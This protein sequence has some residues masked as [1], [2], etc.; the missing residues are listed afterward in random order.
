MTDIIIKIMAELLSVLALATKQIKQGRFSKYDTPYTFLR[1]QCV[2]EKFARKLLGE[3]EVEA[4]LQRLDRL[5][6]D[7]ARMTVAQTLGVVHGLMNNMK[8]VMDGRQFFLD[9]S[10]KPLLSAHYIRWGGIYERHS[11]SLGYVPHSVE[12]FPCSLAV[13]VTL[14]QVV[15]ETNK[16]KCSFPL[17]LLSPPPHRTI[18]TGD[19]LQQEIQRWLS[20]PDPSTNHD[21]V[22]KARHKGTTAWFFEGKVLTEWK[23]KGSLLWIHGK[24]MCLPSPS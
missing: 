2:V 8:V 9:F 6:Q 13:V 19:Q 22:V 3:S 21:F 5:T 11:T 4:I 12:Y 23:S 10:P 16:I 1:T 7:E 15:N 17:F 20:P 18:L 14:H 24:R